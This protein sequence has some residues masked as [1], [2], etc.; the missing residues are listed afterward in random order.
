[1]NRLP[2]WKVSTA[3]RQR[4]TENACTSGFALPK[5]I[6]LTRSRTAPIDLLTAALDEYQAACGGNAARIGQRRS[7]HADRLP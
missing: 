4:G 5:P 1:M 3:T 6:G 7:D 2:S